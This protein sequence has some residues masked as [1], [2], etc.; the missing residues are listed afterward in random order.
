MPV[1]FDPRAITE[2]FNTD[3]EFVLCARYWEGT[4]EFG[5]GDSLYTITM[6]AG[7]VS[8]V[9]VTP[10]EPLADEGRQDGS[11]RVRISAPAGDWEN[12]VKD[13]APPFY[14]DYYSASAHHDFVLDGDRESLWAYYPAIRRTAELFRAL[15]QGKVSA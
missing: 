10:Y 5:V 13:P 11:R 7:K 6:A 15:A 8:G 9:A 14:L 12:M 2:A 3:P 4:L 1:S